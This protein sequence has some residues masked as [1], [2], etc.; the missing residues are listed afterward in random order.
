[1]NSYEIY[2]EIKVENDFISLAK[3]FDFRIDE[4]VSEHARVYVFGLLDD[5]VKINDVLS[6]GSK[7]EFKIIIK[8]PNKAD[9]KFIFDG[10]LEN[11]EI[12]L[13]AGEKFIKLNLISRSFEADGEETTKRYNN[14]EK[15]YVNIFNKI[16]R[17]KYG[18]DLSGDALG[19]MKQEN[20]IVQY[21]ETDW[22][23]LKRIASHANLAISTKPQENGK[24][25][26]LVGFPDGDTKNFDGQVFKKDFYF[27]A[28]LPEYIG[29]STEY[30][31]LCDKVSFE[32]DVYYIIKK[33]I[34]LR[35]GVLFNTYTLTPSE[36]FNVPYVCNR[37][38]AGASLSGKVLGFDK[39]KPNH[40][41]VYLEVDEEEAEDSERL[42][43]VT[44]YSGEGEDMHFG[45]FTM[46]E[47]GAS[48]SLYF[49]DDDEENAYI[50]SSFLHEDLSQVLE[51]QKEKSFY[52]FG[53]ELKMNTESVRMRAKDDRSSLELEDEQGIIIKSDGALLIKS[54]EIELGLKNKLTISAEKEL[55]FKTNASS[56]LL[57]GDIEINASGLVRL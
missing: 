42:E 2:E 43:I 39:D 34:E 51:S 52:A 28:E 6:I 20:L 9:G 3:I 37:K 33:M 50:S 23:F 5:V 40:A 24:L 16:V 56:V 32:G 15:E 17:E 8:Y 30:Y 22:Q 46:P 18:G 31:D 41:S 35:E 21:R 1:M 45:V 47:I 4:R 49:P 27:N 54:A 26:I 29:I 14:S 53:N 36:G 11:F 38:I 7:S 19:D 12:L 44:V 25:E 13:N 55:E 48:V 10:I 57:N